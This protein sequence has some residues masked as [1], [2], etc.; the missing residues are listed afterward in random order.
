MMNGC[1]RWS[2]L[3]LPLLAALGCSDPVPRPPQASLMLSVQV[4]PTTGCP[5][6]GKIYQVGNP[7]PPSGTFAGDPFINGEHGATIKCSVKGGG[8]YT[9]SGSIQALSSESDRV[10]LTVTDGLVAADKLT[11][12]ATI[13]VNTPQL[14]GTY[15][16]PIGACTLTIVNQNVRGGSIWAT[17]T[18]P[19]IG[20]PSTG[21]TCSVGPTTTFVFENCDG[22]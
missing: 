5:V 16:S 6:P 7:K 14:A 12:T 17:A 1:P 20:E 10:T 3:T 4:G 13:A 9:F 11:G 18:C 19:S 8:P 2:F 15:V 22:S 21:K